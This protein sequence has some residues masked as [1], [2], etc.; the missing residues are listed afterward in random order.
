M[1]FYFLNFYWFYMFFLFI[2][3]W[4]AFLVYSKTADTSKEA[5][6]DPEREQHVIISENRE[7]KD[8]NDSIRRSL[9]MMQ[10]VWTKSSVP[11]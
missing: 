4:F 2:V 6:R 9:T 3:V 7:K 8:D 1:N 5:S 10:I 11:A